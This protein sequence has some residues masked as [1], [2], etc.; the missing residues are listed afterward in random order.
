MYV[1]LEVQEKYFPSSW[2]YSTFKDL[3]ESQVRLRESGQNSMVNALKNSHEI[4]GVATKQDRRKT[5]R[6]KI[7]LPAGANIRGRLS[8]YIID[9]SK[10]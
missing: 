7:M 1:R 2:K 4:K 8:P 9:S 6:R 3:L 10:G 5:T